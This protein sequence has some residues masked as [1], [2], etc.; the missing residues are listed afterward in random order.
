MLVVPGVPVAP[1]AAGTTLVEEARLDEL[2]EELEL[3]ELF[4]K[5]ATGLE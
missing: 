5:T 1:G 3:A 4:G 2:D